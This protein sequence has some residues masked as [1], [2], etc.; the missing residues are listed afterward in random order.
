VRIAKYILILSLA[1]CGGTST[2]EAD[3]TSACP[4]LTGRFKTNAT[5]TAMDGECP[6]AKAVSHD[7]ISFDTR[8]AIELP[9]P[10]VATCRTVQRECALNVTCKSELFG[11]VQ[12]VLRAEVAQDGESFSGRGVAVGD[13]QG[14]RRVDY[15]LDAHR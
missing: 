6:W 13:Y 1:A 14:C 7:S 12:G 15:H 9:L 11:G 3:L 8:G 2:V 5:R 10:G 4:L